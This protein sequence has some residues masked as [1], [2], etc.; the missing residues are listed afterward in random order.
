MWACAWDLLSHLGP[1][2]N[3]SSVNLWVS[4]GLSQDLEKGA[5]SKKCG[6]HT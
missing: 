3:P 2:R 6:T 1:G 4:S 5:L